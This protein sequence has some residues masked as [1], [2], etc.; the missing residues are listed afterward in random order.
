MSNSL[1]SCVGPEGDKG[2]KG[3]PCLPADSACV[4]PEGDKGDKGASAN[5]QPGPNGKGITMSTS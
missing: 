4:G 1:S 2:D 3:D 5:G